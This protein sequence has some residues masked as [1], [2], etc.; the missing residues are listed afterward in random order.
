MI[1][2]LERA[3]WLQIPNG[4]SLENPQ[5]VL[6]TV[7]VVGPVCWKKCLYCYQ[8]IDIHTVATLDN[9][10][11]LKKIDSELLLALTHEYYYHIQT[12]LFECVM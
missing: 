8:G 6:L 2:L 4:Y 3:G 5:M 9:G 10:L 12:Q 11:C 7:H 1:Y